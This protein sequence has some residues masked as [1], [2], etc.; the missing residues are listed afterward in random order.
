MHPAFVADGVSKGANPDSP[1]KCL[2]PSPPPPSALVN[3]TG[4]GVQLP[5]SRP[6]C[7]LLGQ[8]QEGMDAFLPLFMGKGL[9]LKAG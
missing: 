8:L 2:Q 3:P 4:A 9:P 1:S 7:G 6:A 5:W